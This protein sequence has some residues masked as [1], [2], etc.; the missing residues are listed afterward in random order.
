MITLI[1]LYCLYIYMVIASTCGAIV[2]ITRFTDTVW[3]L[4]IINLAVFIDLYLIIN[5]PLA[6]LMI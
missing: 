3:T 6:I 5:L 2:Y 4:I 1:L